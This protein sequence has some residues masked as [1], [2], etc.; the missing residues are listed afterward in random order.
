MS[1]LALALLAAAEPLPTI[2][3]FLDGD[4]HAPRSIDVDGQ[5]RE[6]AAHVFVSQW[7]P[8][9]GVPTSVYLPA[10][11]AGART[12]KALGLTAEEMARRTLFALAPLYKLH[13]LD[14]VKLP[15]DQVHDLGEGAIVVSFSRRVNEPPVFRERVAVVLNQQREPVGVLGA[16][17][18]FPAPTLAFSLTAKTALDVALEHTSPRGHTLQP[19]QVL[20]ATDTELLPAW[21]V[22]VDTAAGPY[23]VVVSAKDG[24][25]L[26][27][28]SRTFDFSFRV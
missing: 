4:A 9:T 23:T 18:P 21:Q 3:A 20:F 26:S 13:P 8:R 24:R 10:S 12:P 2:D 27:R 11:P 28:V 5:A 6:A 19:R 15:I 25:L 1:L 14:A 16:F 7:E 22:E 17:S